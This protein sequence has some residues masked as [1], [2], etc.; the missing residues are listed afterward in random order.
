SLSD[1]SGLPGALSIFGGSVTLAAGNRTLRVDT[2]TIDA[3]GR[4]DLSDNAMIV[5]SGD[6]GSW[7]GSTYTGITGQIAAGRGDGSWNG[8]GILTS[9]PAPHANYTTLGVAQSSDA[10]GIGPSDAG[11]WHGQTVTASET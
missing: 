11:V 5:T 6:V 10:L 1:R 7:N 2:L 8:S 9:S 3:T 4:L